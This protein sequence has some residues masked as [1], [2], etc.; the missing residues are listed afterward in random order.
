MGQQDAVSDEHLHVVNGSESDVGNHDI[1][2][3]VQVSYCVI[4]GVH[5]EEFVV[6][7]R[8]EGNYQSRQKSGC[9][10]R[11]RE[12]G[13]KQSS[14]VLEFALSLVVEDGVR[15]KWQTLVEVLPHHEDKEGVVI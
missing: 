5:M 12:E 3:V 15:V 1:E 11:V 10:D 8:R 14:A 13:R 2:E 6:E 9:E 4:V 7:P